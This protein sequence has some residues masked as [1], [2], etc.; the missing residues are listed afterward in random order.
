M[1][2]HDEHSKC[3]AKLRRMTWF[4]LSVRRCQMGQLFYLSKWIPIILSMRID[5]NYF[6][7]ANWYQFDPLKLSSVFNRFKIGGLE[8]WGRIA[9]LYSL[10]VFQHFS[11]NYDSCHWPKFW[12]Q[13]FFD[14]Y[15]IL[16]YVLNKL[17]SFWKCLE[18]FPFIE[19]TVINTP[20][21][22]EFGWFVLQFK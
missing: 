6:I 3:Y 2:P 7:Y 5:T 16:V 12:V 22:F 13:R 11:G 4:K 8:M 10:G 15:C 21:N 14:I 20:Q 9:G 19:F 1:L 18:L 17:G